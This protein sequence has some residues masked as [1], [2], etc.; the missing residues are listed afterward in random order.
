MGSFASR[1]VWRVRRYGSAGAEVD[2]MAATRGSAAPARMAPMAPIEWPEMAPMV[3]SGRAIR[4]WKAASASVPN[5]PA[6]TGSASAVVQAVA[7]HIHGQAV[8]A[9]RVQE[10]GVGQRPVAGRLPAVDEG[11]ARARARHRGPG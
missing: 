9:R 5:S 4:P 11:H 7:A 1:N 2:T 6:L 8:E 10:Q 3:T